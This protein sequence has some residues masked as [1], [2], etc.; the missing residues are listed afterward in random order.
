MTETAAASSSSKA[1]YEKARKLID[2]VHKQD[3]LYQKEASSGT[4]G[5]EG[6]DELAYADA[7]EAWVNALIEKAGEEAFN[8]L[9]ELPG[10]LDLVRLAARCQHLERFATP[11]NT[12][13]DGK[14]GYLQ[15]R[16]TLYVKQ[17]DK[18]VKLLTAAGVC[19]EECAYVHKWVSKTDLKPGRQGGEWGTQVRVR[20][21][22]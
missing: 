9:K 11:R 21:E 20:H 19:Q 13:P 17:A 10:G 16:R 15:W 3:P 4:E 12:F 2:E 14:A 22:R 6:Q 18:A 1:A 7:M 5:V 8:R